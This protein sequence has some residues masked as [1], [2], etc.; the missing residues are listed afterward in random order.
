MTR[1][2][3]L[4]LAIGVS[5][6]LVLAQLLPTARAESPEATI[7]TDGGVIVFLVEGQ[8]K[9]RIDT[10]GLHVNGDVGYSG[11]IADTVTYAPRGSDA[12]GAQ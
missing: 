8:E 5:I 9:A 10:A 3:T 2:T 6:G 4:T 7:K 12:E 11:V 1:T